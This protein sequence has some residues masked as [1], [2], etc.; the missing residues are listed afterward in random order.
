M[1]DPRGVA[2]LVLI[3]P[4]IASS[5]LGEVRFRLD[6]AAA[7]SDVAGLRVRRCV[8]TASEVL[9]KLEEESA[10]QKAREVAKSRAGSGLVGR[11]KSVAR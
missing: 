11:V 7:I 10:A 8:A 5:P 1:Q 4:A 2:A 3:A 6:E 9:A